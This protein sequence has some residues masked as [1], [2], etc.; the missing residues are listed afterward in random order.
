MRHTFA[1]FAVL[2][3]DPIPMVSK[4]LDHTRISSTLRYAHVDDA[5]VSQSAEIIGEVISGIF[6]GQFV[7]TPKNSKSESIQT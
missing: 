2:E 1:S 5:R 4:L 3:G 7:S 6:S